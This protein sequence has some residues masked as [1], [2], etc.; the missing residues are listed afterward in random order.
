[1]CLGSWHLCIWAPGTYATKPPNN[2]KETLGI[3]KERIGILKE[4]IGILIDS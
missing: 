3:P 4:T 2:T 1:M